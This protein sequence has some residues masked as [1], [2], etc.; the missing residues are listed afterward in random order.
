MNI[1]KPKYQYNVPYDANQWYIIVTSTNNHFYFNSNLKKSFWQINDF[2]N[3]IDNKE[4]F[5]KCINFDE[6]SLIFAKNNG[7]NLDQFLKLTLKPK[8]KP[9]ANQKIIEQNDIKN[10]EQ[11]DKE[12][13]LLDDNH[14]DILSNHEDGDDID[15]KEEENILKPD[16]SKEEQ[17]SLIKDLLKE[18][19]YLKDEQSSNEQ[20]IVPSGLNL[21]Y[22]SSDDDEEDEEEKDERE[23]Q[24]T[25][26]TDIPNKSI[27]DEKDDEDEDND[28]VYEDNFKLDLSL[29]D[30]DLED[31][32]QLD[33]SISDTEQS[34]SEEF[35][36]LLN[37]FKEK[38]SIYDPWFLVEEE[39]I[40]EFIKYPGFYSIDEKDRENVF[41]EW[42]K[43][44][45]SHDD[46][47][48]NQSEHN[49]VSEEEDIDENNKT[50]PTV[51]QLYFKFL[52]KFKP[53]L[54][55][56]LFNEF[57]L[58]HMVNNPEFDIIVD[59]L[60][61]KDIEDYFRLFR[62]TI[63]EF[64][65]FEKHVK[66]TN[67]DKS[68]NKV[69]LKKQKVD[70]FLNSKKSTIENEVKN[71][72]HLLSELQL[73]KSNDANDD[74]YFDNW[75]ELCNFFNLSSDIVNDPTNFIVGN[76]KR[77]QSYYEFIKSISK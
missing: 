12:E 14:E 19:G 43:L 35:H 20:T 49:E 23:K 60:S 8:Q 41:N 55:N 4:S 47:L 5:L 22:S 13:V 48:T 75:I 52:Q 51:I 30:S 2:Q 46:K 63:N 6:L 18:E 32:N 33:L 7:L 70:D 17:E 77:F 28:E 76:E 29:P 10:V 40:N 16:I 26:E 36:N 11:S 74:V 15:H 69:N 45:E 67:K 65:K 1:G 50:F 25:I 66:K 68:Q 37:Q 61:A 58:K 57:K 21:G 73:N 59:Q 42:V 53:E 31:E 71:L 27:D 72:N 64:S 62:I 24:T 34:S 44:Q 38:I 3:L 39:L 56:S 9:K 54:K